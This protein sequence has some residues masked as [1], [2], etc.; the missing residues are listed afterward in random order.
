MPGTRYSC[1]ARYDW[2]P[3]CPLRAKES[4]ISW[5]SSSDTAASCAM[6]VPNCSTP[7]SRTALTNSSEKLT[8]ERPNTASRFADQFS[9]ASRL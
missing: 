5:S 1:S 3:A 8:P 6:T 2:T 7:P 4:D 9:V